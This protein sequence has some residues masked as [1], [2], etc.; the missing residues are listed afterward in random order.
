[1]SKGEY[2][3]PASS[4]AAASIVARRKQQQRKKYL[5]WGIIGGVAVLLILALFSISTDAIELHRDSSS[6]NE[7]SQNQ[8]LNS[9]E[10]SKVA[11]EDTSSDE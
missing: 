3:H 11:S 10:L 6:S 4:G 8:N 5:K 1:M 7:A 2:V 9:V